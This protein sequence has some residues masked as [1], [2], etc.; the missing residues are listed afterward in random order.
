[1]MQRL[2]GNLGRLTHCHCGLPVPAG[3]RVACSDQHRVDRR[4]QQLL[5][6]TR[7]HKYGITFQEQANLW[8]DQGGRCASC[9]TAFASPAD[10]DLDHCHSSGRIRAFLCRACN[11]TVGMCRE[12]VDRLINVAEY[13]IAQRSH[14]RRLVRHGTGAMSIYK[15]VSP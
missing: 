7:K 1:M 12:D 15:G 11:F 14:I 2:R 6:N 5:E 9:S 10:A 8:N 4:T 3:Q 13:L